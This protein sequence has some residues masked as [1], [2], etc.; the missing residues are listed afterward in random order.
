MNPYSS[1]DFSQREQKEVRSKGNEAPQ[2]EHLEDETTH[3]MV[4]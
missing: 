4:D 1:I 3:M 2:M